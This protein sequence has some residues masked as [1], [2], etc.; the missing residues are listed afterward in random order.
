VLWELKVFKTQDG[1]IRY[2]KDIIEAFGKMV[3][4][5]F[6]NF[7]PDLNK[8]LEKSEEANNQFFETMN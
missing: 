5:E 4:I 2:K 1:Q 7:H 8:T 3:G 6:K